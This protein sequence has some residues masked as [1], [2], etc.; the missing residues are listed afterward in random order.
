MSTK[1]NSGR[2][3]YIIPKRETIVSAASGDADSIGKLLNFYKGYICSLSVIKY[4]TGEDKT[5]VFYDEDLRDGLMQK[6]IEAT[7]RFDVN[8]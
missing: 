1:N 5:M 2:K 7:L 6:L 4:R 8:R 3:E